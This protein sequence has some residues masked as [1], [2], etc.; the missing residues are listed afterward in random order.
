M[1]RSQEEIVREK[2]M[3]VEQN[4]IAWNKDRV[5][6]NVA[7]AQ[8][9]KKG[10]KNIYYA[11]ASVAATLLVVLLGIGWFTEKK[12]VQSLVT[13]KRAQPKGTTAKVNLTPK[14]VD[15]GNKRQP[16]VL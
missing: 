1:E 7:I 10:T 4:R 3:L 13:N 15:A 6:Q 16:S 12:P 5:W 8:P 11:V 9:I 2:I 14:F